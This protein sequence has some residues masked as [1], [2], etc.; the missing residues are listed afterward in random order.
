[1]EIKDM[2]IEDIEKRMSEIEVEKV[3][4]E[5]DLEALTEEVRALKEQ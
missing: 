3:N 4:P 1:M 5:A 2:K